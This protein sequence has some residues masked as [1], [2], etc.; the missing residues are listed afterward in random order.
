MES[1]NQLWIVSH[2]CFEASRR[3]HILSDMKH[4]EREKSSSW[5]GGAR[6]VL[7]TRICCPIEYN[8]RKHQHQTKPLCDHDGSRQKQNHLHKLTNKR[9][10]TVTQPHTPTPTPHT[11]TQRPN[12]PLSWLRDC[13]FLTNHSFSHSRFFSLF[14]V[15]ITKIPIRITFISFL[16]ASN[17]KR[18]PASWNP[19]RLP[20]TS[21][22]PVNSFQHPL[23]DMPPAPQAVPP[24]L[25]RRQ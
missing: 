8:F 24:L 15:R 4:S 17:P 9:T 13:S 19:P 5:I 12:I 11:H 1:A 20:N 25:T 16:T 23:P 14:Q 2:S 10:R 3:E 21:S 22:N 7:S 6:L 18:R